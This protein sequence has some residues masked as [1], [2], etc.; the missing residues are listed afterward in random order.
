MR[1]LLRVFI[2]PKIIQNANIFTL[3]LPALGGGGADDVPLVT[4]FQTAASPS[5]PVKKTIQNCI[6]F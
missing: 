5:S 4:G 1:I 3:F 2:F 6:K